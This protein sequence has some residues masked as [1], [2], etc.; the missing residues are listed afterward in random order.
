MGTWLAML[1]AIAIAHRAAPEVS[2][3]PVD[4]APAP[5]PDGVAAAVP[6]GPRWSVKIDGWTIKVDEV[7]KQA[8]PALEPEY[9]TP[10]LSAYDQMIAR[11]AEA[12]GLD[13]RFVSAVI[14]EESRFDA[15]SRSPAGAVG[16]M[17]VMPA[18][19][20]DVG[21]LQ[22]HEPEANVRAG[23]RYL[24]RLRREYAAASERDR[25]ALMLAAYN[26]GMGHVRDAQRLARRFGY[27]PL[28]WDG[29]MDVMIALLEEPQ[30][31]AKMRY[32]YAQG[33]AVVGYVERILNRYASYRRTLPPI[34]PATVAAG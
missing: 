3:A 29:A 5:A 16:L 17:Q 7:A 25:L 9:V 27:D 33:R 6:S 18:A 4:L 11:Y 2:P 21:E 23:V 32:G 31:A 24:Q 10:V 12:A 28:R 13:W 26:M 20:Q 8:I 22:F 19:A 34:F 1:A 15:D 14:Y 30:I